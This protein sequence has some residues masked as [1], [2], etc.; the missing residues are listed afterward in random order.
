WVPGK[1]DKIRITLAT[2]LFL[3]IQ[4]AGAVPPVVAEGR[5][6]TEHKDVKRGVVGSAA[7]DI[8]LVLMTNSHW[9]ADAIVVHL[10]WWDGNGIPNSTNKYKEDQKVSWHATPFE[11]RLEKALSEDK[12]I[13]ERKQLR[14]TFYNM[15]WLSVW[16]FSRVIAL[17]IENDYGAVWDSLL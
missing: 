6:D 10:W 5:D 13:V 8:D 7:T 14:K 16:L 3:G 15:D 9:N 12:I 1:A 11:E 17:L 4:N 2:V